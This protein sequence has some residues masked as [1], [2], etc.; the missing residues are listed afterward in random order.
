VP[1]PDPVYGETPRAVV[2]AEGVTAEELV[3]FARA[4]LAPFKVPVDFAFVDELPRNPGGKI[5]KQLLR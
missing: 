2:V 4:R 1:K 3:E 5:L